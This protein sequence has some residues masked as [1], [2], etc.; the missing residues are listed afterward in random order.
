MDCITFED[1]GV[2]FALGT[3]EGKIYIRID[4]EECSKYCIY[5]NKIDPMIVNLKLTI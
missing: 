4:W 3:I 1:S 2:V 5:L